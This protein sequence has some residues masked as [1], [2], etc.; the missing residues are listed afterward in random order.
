MPY[1]GGDPRAR[2]ALERGMTRAQASAGPGVQ[3]GVSK[4]AKPMQITLKLRLRDKHATALDCQAR[5]VNV[6]WNYANETQQKAVRALRPW[7][8]V[9]DLMRLTAG[10]S[11]DLDLHAHTIQRVC[12]AYDD[13]RKTRKK[14]WL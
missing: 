11:K 4:S 13:A 9:Y 12:R 10:A 8:S 5:A 1:V 3:A 7:L 6:V 14:A 2:M